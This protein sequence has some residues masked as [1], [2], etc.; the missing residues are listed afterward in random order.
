MQKSENNIMA[1]G[2]KRIF[3][4]GVG[5]LVLVPILRASTGLPPYLGIMLGLG[6]MWVLT[7]LI[8][9]ERHFLRVPHILTKVDISSVLFFLGILLAVAALQMAGILD[10]LTLWMDKYIGSK[11]IIVFS[12]GAISS[13]IDNVPLTAA[14]MGMYDLS[15]YPVDSKLWEMTAY[16]V[17][18]G[19]SMLIVGSASGVVVMGLEKISFGWYLKKISFPAILGYLAGFIAF[20]VL[21][22]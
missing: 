14:L 15:K 21:Y 12:M 2:A 6:L 11:D 16:C 17:G 4:L 8:H 3:L 9:Q 22:P 13:I 5:A 18:T 1:H 7:D 10:R 20:L 19:G